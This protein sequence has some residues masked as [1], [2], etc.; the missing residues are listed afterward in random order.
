MEK[1]VSIGKE[2]P[3]CQKMVQKRRVVSGY[4]KSIIIITLKLYIIIYIYIPIRPIPP[5]PL[6]TLQKN[7]K[8]SYTTYVTPQ[9]FQDWQKR[10]RVTKL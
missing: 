9:A 3:L 4:N 2:N 8:I 5:L 10:K 6:Q 7:L 1:T